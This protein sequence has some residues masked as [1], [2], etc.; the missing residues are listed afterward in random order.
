M[1]AI[2]FDTYGGPEVLHEV[3]LPDPRPGPGEILVRVDAA[4]VAPVDAMARSGGL[5]ALYE[6][7]TTC[8]AAGENPW[9]G[10]AALYE[11]ITPPYVP[12]MDVCGVVEEVGEGASGGQENLAVGARVVAFVAFSGSRGGYSEAV[13]VP[14]VSAVRAPANATPS[15]AVAF[16]LNALTARNSL[17]ALAL[18]P[19]ATVLV[20]GAAGSVGGYITQLAYAE[21]LHVI[22]LAGAGDESLV[23][24]FG[25]E[26]FIPRGAD[27]VAEARALAPDG[28]DAVADTAQIAV[29]LLGAVRDGGRVSILRPISQD[30]PGRGITLLPLTVRKRA[31]DQAAMAGLRDLIESRT[32]SI[33]LGPVLPASQAAEAH[34]LL[35][36]GGQRGRIVLT[37]PVD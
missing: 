36:A 4:G 35:E 32:L 26:D 15:E 33:R 18:P 29:D 31:T 30:D 11:G 28:V 17:D 37:F 21:G 3:E 24:G 8:R 10:L 7:I 2:G 20:T 5:A 23:R 12:G 27:V 14:A 22:A 6:G 25:A 1:R 16:L 34:R 9:T 13:V 19:G